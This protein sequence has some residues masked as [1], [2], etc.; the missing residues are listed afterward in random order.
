MDSRR[1]EKGGIPAGN[2]TAKVAPK[3]ILSVHNAALSPPGNYR[4]I[5][6]EFPDTIWMT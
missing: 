6:E 2:L 1:R 4:P 3:G 5:V